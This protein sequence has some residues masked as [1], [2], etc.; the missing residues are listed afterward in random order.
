LTLFEDGLDNNQYKRGS[1]KFL[2]DGLNLPEGPRMLGLEWIG[3]DKP[4]RR[5]TVQQARPDTLLMQLVLQFARLSKV[6]VIADPAIY[7]TLP[8]YRSFGFHPFALI[9]RG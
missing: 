2:V 8:F 9:E 6:S 1:A 3:V 4:H 5:P 7:R